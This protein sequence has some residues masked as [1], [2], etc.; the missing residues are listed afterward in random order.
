MSDMSPLAYFEHLSARFKAI[1][2]R[3]G[4]GSAIGLEAGVNLACSIVEEVA[5][6]DRKVLFIGNGGS[7]AI[8]SHMAVDF[9][10][11]G[12]IK[13]MAFNDSSGLTCIGNDYGYS[14]V[15]EKP[16]E[17]FAEEGD[18]LISISSSGCSENILNGVHAARE[19]GARIITL[20]GF[21]CDNPLCLMGECN[22]Y[23][24]SSAYGFVEIIH[25]A[26]CHSILDIYMIR[27]GTLEPEKLSDG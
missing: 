8:A 5:R 27:K 10:K 18:L 17:L 25:Q 13:A 19:K 7:A 12:G 26:I 6:A 16:L 23:V 15:F 9:W 4:K 22:F 21:G 24:P 20:S 1:E 11:N 3:D 2:A 14:H